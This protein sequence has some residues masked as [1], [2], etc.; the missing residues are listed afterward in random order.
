M[1]TCRFSNWY[2]FNL[3]T[4]N[5][6][7]KAHLKQQLMKEI[8]IYEFQLKAIKEALRVAANSFNCRTQKTC[9]DRMIVQAEKYA[10][11]A[12]NENKDIEVVYGLKQQS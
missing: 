6:F 10:E 1:G 3:N 11:N 12:L 2:H 9:L 7:Q 4:S 5:N 8:T